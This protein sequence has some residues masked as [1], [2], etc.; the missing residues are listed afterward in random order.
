MRLKTD[1]D[2]LC[3]ICALTGQT[4]VQEHAESTCT[5]STVQI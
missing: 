3:E 2:I 4:P 1:V 5:L